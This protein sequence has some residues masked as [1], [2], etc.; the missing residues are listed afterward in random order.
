MS[1]GPPVSSMRFRSSSRRLRMY[2]F[3]WPIIDAAVSPECPKVS[4]FPF[5]FVRPRPVSLT[6]GA[7]ERPLPLP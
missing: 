6:T 1:H 2:L 4:P 7:S 5:V 3:M